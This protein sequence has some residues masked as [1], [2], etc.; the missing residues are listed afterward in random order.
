MRGIAFST[1]RIAVSSLML[2]E[3][4]TPRL[5]FILIVRRVGVFYAFR[6]SV[7]TRLP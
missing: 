3:Y 1:L 5:F 2:Y 4:S 6:R 7:V